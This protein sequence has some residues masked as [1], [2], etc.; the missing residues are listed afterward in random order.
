MSSRLLTAFA[1]LLVVGNVSAA[2][3]AKR[4]N[5]LFCIADDWGYPH[6]GAYGDKVVRTPVFDR[7][8]REG[9][10]FT[11]AFSASPSCTPSRAAILT[12]RAVH[13]LREDANLWSTLPK[14][15]PTY[16]EVLTRTGYICGATRKGWGPGNVAAGGRT[17]PPA[18]KNFKDFDSFLETVPAGEPF[19][20]WFG[21]LDPHR[22]YDKGTGAAAGL[23][24][25]NVVVP[26]YW[27]DTAEVRSD[28][29]DYHFEVERFDRDVGALLAKLEARGELDN[30]LVVITGDNGMPF[31]RCKANVYD[32]GSRQPFA[33][34][35]PAHFSGGR[36]NDAFVNLY[37]LSATFLDAA[38][39]KPLK[40]MASR[41]ILPLC[42]GERGGD[43]S[44]VF[45]ER[46]RHANVRP[47]NAGYP[48]RAVRTKDYLYIRNLRPDRWPAGDPVLVHSV[49]PFGDC[50][51]G[52]TK[53]VIL[54]DRSSDAGKAFFDLCFGKRP[55]EELYD[56]R[57]DPDQI[58]NLADKPELARTKE[59]LQ[60]ALENWRRD[61]GDPRMEK[62]DDWFDSVR[63][64]GAPAK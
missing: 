47:E 9:V 13:A 62:D 38:G 44:M 35:W 16:V 57:R 58:T 23:N 36:T 60:A 48:I 32:G 19:C 34:R 7:V 21:G 49:G 20:F 5:I 22:P 42:R 30:T 4:P 54:A 61:T 18:G 40:E 53:Q 14:D 17:G 3:K 15:I 39:L 43:R 33:M 25:T 29:L 63:Y 51:D 2:D 8:A 11:H 6:A 55:G 27:P 46:E 41:S 59:R 64:F 50:D 31:P 24:P 10:L 56:V 26:K 12:G 37:D 52:P 45:L 1:F 28:V